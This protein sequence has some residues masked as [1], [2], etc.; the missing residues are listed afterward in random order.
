MTHGHNDLIIAPDPRERRHIVTLIASARRRS[1]DE[2]HVIV[3]PDGG[4]ARHIGEIAR[5]GTAFL[6]LA[7][8]ESPH[9]D[10]NLLSSAEEITA[11][12]TVQALCRSMRDAWPHWSGRIEDTMRRA[13]AVTLERNQKGREPHSLRQ[14]LEVA[15]TLAYDD[16]TAAAIRS[17]T[18]RLDKTSEESPATGLQDGWPHVPAIKEGRDV[19]VDGAAQRIGHESASLVCNWII[20]AVR[21]W[22][23]GQLWT[24]RGQP[25]RHVHIIADQADQ[26]GG[27]Y[28]D[29]MVADTDPKLITY[30][31]CNVAP[32]P[33]ARRGRHP[34]SLYDRITATKMPHEMATRVAPLLD[35]PNLPV[36]PGTLRTL[37]EKFVVAR[38]RDR[39]A[40]IGPATEIIGGTG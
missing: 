24:A 34:E 27:A 31:V 10:L 8:R 12:A 35:S 25:K 36:G 2:S 33:P 7:T 39:A 9:N 4:L 30:T 38:E 5:P 15:L 22:A 6:T 32:A 40:R 3:S 13:L 23:I 17:A 29:L 18:H 26:I 19:I 1:P 16:E 28:W 14:S 11:T 21:E 20:T 37:P